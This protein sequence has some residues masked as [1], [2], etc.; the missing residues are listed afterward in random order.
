MTNYSY[1]SLSRI[2]KAF[3]Y[4]SIDDLSGLPYPGSLTTYN[5]G[6]YIADLSIS[7]YESSLT[8]TELQNLMWIDKWTRG[9]FVEFTIYNP[10][11]NLFA[12]VNYLFEFPREGSVIPY[13]RIMA[14]QVYKPP[15]I[16]G[17]IN[18]IC[19]CIYC[20]VIFY[21]LFKQIKELKLMGFKK[22]LRSAW[23]MLECT[24]IITS[25]FSNWDVQFEG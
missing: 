21:F 12:Y 7:P 17:V 14:F 8:M 16:Q 6:G 2:E 5:G 11:V 9:V 13:T 19:L 3:A 15:G 20:L 10:N 18:S 1:E 4:Q 25:F 23:N 22:Y 24:V